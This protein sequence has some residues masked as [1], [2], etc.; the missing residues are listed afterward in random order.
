[1][2]KIIPPNET[3]KHGQINNG[4]IRFHESKSEKFSFNSF[5]VI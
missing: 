1:M 4:D 5:F 3:V 2:A